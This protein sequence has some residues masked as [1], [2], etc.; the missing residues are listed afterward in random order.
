VGDDRV[1]AS[2]TK[3][4]RSPEAENSRRRPTTDD[5]RAEHYEQY[6]QSRLESRRL[7]ENIPPSAKSENPKSVKMYTNV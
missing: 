5:R 4:A 6:Q 1:A 2:E 7:A 3:K